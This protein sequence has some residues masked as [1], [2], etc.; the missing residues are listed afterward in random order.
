MPFPSVF[1]SSEFG[2]VSFGIP[3]TR[4]DRNNVD[5]GGGGFCAQ[6]GFAKRGG[7]FVLQFVSEI[8]RGF[9]VL[10]SDAV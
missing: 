9:C 10:T 6:G 5:Y 7:S 8:E 1:I 3:Y 4:E 2:C